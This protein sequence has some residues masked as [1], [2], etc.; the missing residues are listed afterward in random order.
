M[1]GTIADLA[2]QK[3]NTG[4]PV[5]AGENAT[6]NLVVTNNGPSDS[7]P[8]ISVVDRLPA[9]VEFVSATGDGWACTNAP[10]TIVSLSSVVTCTRAA[11]LT[12]QQGVNDVDDN[13]IAPPIVLV[14]RVLPG[15]RP[16][17]S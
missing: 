1:F 17:A 6:W 8:V 15:S 7:Q 3:T 12:A 14:A 5:K 10:S 13:H 2:I 11:V 9:S 4:S 16:G